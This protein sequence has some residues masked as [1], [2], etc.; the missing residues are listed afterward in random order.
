MHS[1][2]HSLTPVSVVVCVACKPRPCPSYRR[3]RDGI[4]L[5]LLR[6]CYRGGGVPFTTLPLLGSAQELSY[7]RVARPFAG[8]FQP[9]CNLPFF[10]CQQCSWPIFCH[11]TA[12]PFVATAA[13]AY[14]WHPPDT[15]SI[16]AT[17][18]LAHWLPQHTRPMPCPPSLPPSVE[19]IE[20][21]VPF[22]TITTAVWAYVAGGGFWSQV[23]LPPQ[24][25]SG[26]GAPF[27]P[28]PAP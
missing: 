27:P 8:F 22:N 23:N 6:R 19:I 7:H 14:N 11:L 16:A 26:R 12:C 10:I 18:Q 20:V 24:G 15:H 28:S 17:L 5:V 13:A 25:G 1:Y 9:Q 21:Y 3:R 4:N 2:Q